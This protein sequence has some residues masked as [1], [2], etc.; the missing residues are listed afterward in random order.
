[1]SPWERFVVPNLIACACSSKPIMKQRAKVVP[2]AYGEVLELG[3]GSGT[4]FPF[5]DAGKVGQL[6]ALE[7][8]PGMLVK[9]RRAADMLPIGKRTSFLEAGAENVP[10]PDRSI[11][12]VVITFVLCTIPN[13]QGALKET[14]RVLKPGG[15]V[16]YSEHGLSPDAGVSKWQRRVEP[17]WKSIAGGCHLT[18]DTAAML[19][20]SG[21]VLDQ[22][23]T[24]YLPST[25]QIA[26][27]VSWGHAHFAG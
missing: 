1:V 16:V 10:L 8:S 18:R 21:F 17:V 2:D 20:G 25:P 4:N 24:M 27:Y 22:H 13:W 12:T 26:G 7:P 23:Q 3:C 6:Y 9:A 11:D 14:A 19:Q 15:L 5:Y